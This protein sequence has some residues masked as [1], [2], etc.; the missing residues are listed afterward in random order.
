MTL[1]FVSA[2]SG[3]RLRMVSMRLPTSAWFFRQSFG[4]MWWSSR[5]PYC[6]DIASHPVAGAAEHE[7]VEDPVVDRGPTLHLLAQLER[8]EPATELRRSAGSFES[9]P[10]QAL[11]SRK[12]RAAVDSTEP[13]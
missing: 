13:E 12:S 9:S 2:V 6:G 7:Q 3:V 11:T 8:A 4:T 1:R 10:N 5:S